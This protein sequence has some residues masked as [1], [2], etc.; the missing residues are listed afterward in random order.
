MAVSHFEIIR[1][2]PF[3]F[4][5]ERIDG[6]LHFAVDPAHPANA[7][8]TDLHLAPRA[9]DGFLMRRGWTVAFCGWQWDIDPLPGLTGLEAPQA[10]GP[11]GKPLQGKVTIAFQPNEVQTHHHLSHWP[12]YPPPGRQ[13]FL[14]R[15]Y[16]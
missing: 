14:H 7:R 4:D 11:D 13:T 9:A 1:R 6:T 10:L 2:A 15:P 12:L 16:P 8:I 5:Y 3:A